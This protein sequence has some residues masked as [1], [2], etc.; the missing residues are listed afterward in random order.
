MFYLMK[1]VAKFNLIILD[2]MKSEKEYAEKLISLTNK[3][4]TQKISLIKKTSV[5]IT[6]LNYNSKKGLL[7]KEIKSC[8]NDIKDIKKQIPQYSDLY[9]NFE[10][11]E[12]RWKQLSV[13]VKSLNVN[14]IKSF[15]L[16]LNKYLADYEKA[17][18]DTQSLMQSEINDIDVFLN[19]RKVA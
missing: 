1:S 2:A 13:M 14:N 3:I 8:I 5:T 9:S 18:I 17:L 12:A 6:K 4:I 7:K 11:E 19:K 16:T 15:K 10:A